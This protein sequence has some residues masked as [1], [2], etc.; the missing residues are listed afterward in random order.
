MFLTD[1]LLNIYKILDDHVVF[2][3]EECINDNTLFDQGM[4]IQ[5]MV[6]MKL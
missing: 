1:E 3:Y 5:Y 2:M 4:H 6:I